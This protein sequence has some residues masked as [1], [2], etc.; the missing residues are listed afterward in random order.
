MDALASAALAGL[1]A[2]AFVLVRKVRVLARDVA[3]LSGRVHE[4]SGRLQGAEQ[5]VAAAVGRAEVAEAV[6]LEKG[7][8]DEEDLEAARRRSGE[9]A[10]DSA[11]G[12]DV[13]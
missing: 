1:S 12:G 8:A 13:H 7:L 11:R 3:E 2:L 4:L 9:A 6:L 5:D 10:H